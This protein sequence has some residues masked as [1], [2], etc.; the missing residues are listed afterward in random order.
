VST[1]YAYCDAAAARAESARPCVYPR[2]ILATT[3]LASSLA[4]I[5]GSVVNVALPAIGRALSADADLLQWC[6]NAYLLP[7]SAL[8]LLGGGAGDRFGRRR[9]L[10]AGVALFAVASLGC[11]LAPNLHVLLVARF[12]QGVGAAALTPNSLAILGESFSGAAKGRAIGMW[13]ASSAVAGALGPVLGGWL[14]DLGSWRA[15][16]LIN[17]PL[18]LAAILLAW[19]YVPAATLRRDQPLD[20]HGGL[21][22]TAGLGVLTWA[23]TVATGKAGWS[24]ATVAS[25]GAGAAL[26]IVFL[27][28]Q[29]QRGER[30][31]IP[32][33]LFGSRN[34]LGLNTLTLLLYGA[35][36]ALLVLLPYVLIEAEGYSAV[37]AGAALLPLPIV[38]TLTSPLT[39]ALAAGTGAKAPIVIGTVTVGIGLLLMLR[40]SSH[41]SYWRDLLPALLVLSVGLSTA[42]APLTTAVLSSV[43]AHY[44]GSASGLNSAVARTGGLVATALLGTVLAS[45]GDGLLTSFHAAMS[46]AALACLLAAVSAIALLKR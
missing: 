24:A 29:G 12:C 4:F 2:W 15:I 7:L 28:V 34:L 1:I 10:I 9:V 11:A 42:V 20:V 37:A 14:I 26:L 38:L 5:D 27:L 46:F 23:L 3:I 31:L 45:R 6:I 8:L 17:L 32:L 44:N 25:A 18:A 35:L 30:A 33:A 41:A 43:D 21:L 36:G 16:F 19:R 39:G 40:V 13:S 22:V